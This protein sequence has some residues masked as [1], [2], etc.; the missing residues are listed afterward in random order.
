MKNS[1]CKFKLIIR[2]ISLQLDVILQRITKLEFDNFKA[3]NLGNL[4]ETFDKKITESVDKKVDDSTANLCR[5]LTEA[6]DVIRNK[7]DSSYAMHEGDKILVLDTL[8][9]EEAKN[10]IIVSSGAVFQNGANKPY[11]LR[12]EMRCVCIQMPRA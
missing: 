9:K 12:L 10:V 1:K 2:V 3:E 11:V 4:I 6:T 7:L 5:K 8:P